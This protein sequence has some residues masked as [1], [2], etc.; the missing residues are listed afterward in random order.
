MLTDMVAPVEIK[1]VISSEDQHLVFVLD[2]EVCSSTLINESNVPDKEQMVLRQR[3]KRSY[4]DIEDPSDQCKTTQDRK[5][6]YQEEPSVDPEVE[7]SR[8]NAITAKQN[9]D[10]KKH[11]IQ[12]LETSVTELSGKNK[13]LT[14]ENAR[15][16]S[17][18]QTLEDEVLYLKSILQNESS[19]A[20]LLSNMKDLETIK[21]SSSFSRPSDGKPSPVGVSGGICLHT[22]GRNVSVEMCVECSRRANSSS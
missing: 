14:S 12:E 9:R 8:K 15:I 13:V 10:K 19:L 4:D 21:L 7:K 22:N 16:K 20:S 18:L 6:R 2:S 1:Q 11:Y 17:N 3:K 5:R